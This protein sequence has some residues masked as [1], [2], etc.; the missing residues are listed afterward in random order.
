M[1]P[2]WLAVYF[3]QGL[4]PKQIDS[5]VVDIP[6]QQLDNMFLKMSSHLHKVAKAMPSHA[7]SLK[8]SGLPSTPGVPKLSLYGVRR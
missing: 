7:E 6:K 2:S 3:G 8:N 5:R 1:S 4:Y